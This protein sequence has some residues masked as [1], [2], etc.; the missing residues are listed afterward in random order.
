MDPKAFLDLSAELKKVD[1]ESYLRTSVSRSY[2]ALF[3]QLIIFLEN[4]GHSM[5]KTAEDHKKA[6]LYLGNCGVEDVEVV[7]SDLDNLRIERNHADYDLNCEEFKNPLV[8]IKNYL[9]ASAAYENFLNATNTRKKK[10]N[11]SKGI[12]AYRRKTNQI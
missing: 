3:N 12:L 2:Y 6:Y 9:T 8:V 10:E 11:I 1:K 4:N 7:A 5:T